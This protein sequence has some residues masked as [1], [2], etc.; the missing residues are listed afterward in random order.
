MWM[1]CLGWFRFDDWWRRTCWFILVDNIV[2]TNMRMYL[3]IPGSE[4]DDG[5]SSATSSDKCINTIIIIILIILLS[6]VLWRCFG[7][8][9]SYFAHWLVPFSFFDSVVFLVCEIR[10]KLIIIYLQFIGFGTCIH[11]FLMMFIILPLV[12]FSGYVCFTDFVHPL[13]YWRGLLG[14]WSEYCRVTHSVN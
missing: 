14:M 11:L 6:L 5:S 2:W 7:C 4:T 10:W 9:L 13:L 8:G 3:Y 12:L 1:I